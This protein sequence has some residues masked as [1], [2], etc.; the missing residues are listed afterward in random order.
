MKLFGCL[1]ANKLTIKYKYISKKLNPEL[2]AH[3]QANTPFEAFREEYLTQS[4]KGAM[5]YSKD[6]NEFEASNAFIDRLVISSRL[7]KDI[8]A[9]AY[10]DYADDLQYSDMTITQNQ[11]TNKL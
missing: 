6:L 8:T 9:E 4:L 7:F 1:V 5:M 3:D 2:L 11:F 10:R